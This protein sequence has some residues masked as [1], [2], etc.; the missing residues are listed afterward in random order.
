M[1]GIHYS[2]YELVGVLEI[3]S[4]PAMRKFSHVSFWACSELFQNA[5]SE[6][7]VQSSIGKPSGSL[8][9]YLSLISEPFS[10]LL[11]PLGMFDDTT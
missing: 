2:V 6:C 4:K 11:E 10:L 9:A 8:H 5:G 3:V 1:V 7:S